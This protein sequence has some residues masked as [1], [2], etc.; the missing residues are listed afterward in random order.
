VSQTKAELI[1]GLNINASAPATALN[2]DSSGSVGIGTTS[3]STLLA[4]AGGISGTAGINVSGGGW[5]V[6]PY[7]A[8]SLVIDSTAGQTRLFATGTDASTHGNLLFFTG[9]TNGTASERARID[10][11]GR[12]LVG[13]SS[14]NANGGILQLTSGITFPATAVAAS[15]PNTLDDYEEGTWTPTQGG[16]LTVVGTFSSAGHYTKVG[17][18][19]T[20]QGYVQST[21][22]VAAAANAIICGGL[23]FTVMNVTGS[24]FIGSGSNANL[25]ALINVWANQAST[26]IYAV[27]SM[28]AT[29]GI[30]FT[31]S[32]FTA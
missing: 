4:V 23:P 13:T 32:Y 17:R 1:K 5:G 16:G 20:V 30:Y 27:T 26:N 8:N 3:P 15:D 19:V 11:S 31:V 28:A 12:L 18:Q 6:L 10:S 9:T 29:A 7:V 22:T 24:H 2:I 14:G 21:T 25:S